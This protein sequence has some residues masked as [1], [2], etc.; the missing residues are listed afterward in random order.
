MDVR[1]DADQAEAR[2]DSAFLTDAFWSHAHRDD[3]LEHV[4]IAAS[5]HG[6]LAAVFIAAADAHEGAE[7]ALALGRRLVA[8][9]PALAGWYV[10]SCA[11]LSNSA[12]NGA[13]GKPHSPGGSGAS[14]DT[15]TGAG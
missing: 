11:V 7:A 3:G 13:P 9:V 6:F 12:V 8:A 5:P 1:T 2:L 10:E 14:T 15:G 4:R